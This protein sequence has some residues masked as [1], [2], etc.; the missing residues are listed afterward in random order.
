MRY[1][2]GIATAEADPAQIEFPD[3]VRG[4]FDEAHPARR[5]DLDDGTTYRL[6]HVSGDFKNDFDLHRYP[7]DTQ[8]LDIQFFNARASSNRLVY[9]IDRAGAEARGR[10]ASRAAFRNLSQWEP[11]DVTQ[12]R[13]N[14][15]TE[16]A[17][18]DPALIGVENVRELSGF[19]LRAEVRRLIGTTLIKTL[20]P[21]GLMT[22]IM[23]ATFFFPA[24]LAGAK[25]TVAITAGLSGAVLLA[26]INAQL[27]N[28]G[29]V[30]AVEYG[31]Y[32]F[33]ALSLVCIVTT[34]ISEKRRLADRSTAV[35][36]NIG[37][38]LFLLGFLGT[39]V[40]ASVAFWQWQ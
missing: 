12:R 19:A 10:S 15:V 16:S 40:A 18:G 17:I 7:A 8:W 14:L 34:L 28:L 35:V 27:G 25:V 4:K 39:I 9:V 31:F 38:G 5:R 29:Y 36:D 21:L 6:W 13:D 2:P 23:F 30:I 22:M 37:R 32:V 1:A 26:A 3:M 33:F 11:R 24:G 20:L